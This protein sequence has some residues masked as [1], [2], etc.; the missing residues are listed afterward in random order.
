M[1]LEAMPE[2]LP[3]PGTDGAWVISM[4]LNGRVHLATSVSELM[5]ELDAG[6]PRTGSD[7]ERLLA[8]SRAAIWYARVAQGLALADSSTLGAYAPH[9]FDAEHARI[10]FEDKAAAVSITAPWTA[11]V[12]LMLVASHYAPYTS[13]PRPA[14]NVVL[15]DPYTEESF[16]ASLQ[17][18]G[19]LQLVH[20]TG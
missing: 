16:A 2:E 10:A 1:H 9:A 5:T 3:P 12:P 18:A 4:T 6:Y 11:T 15:I 17:Q 7:I 19:I 8:R 13:L 14:G 20:L